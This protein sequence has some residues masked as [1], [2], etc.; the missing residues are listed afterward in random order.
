MDNTRDTQ[1]SPASH[2][3]Q[4]PALSRR[5]IAARRANAKN[6]TGPRT[7]DGKDAVRLNA[8]KH[9][10]FARD[11]V[12]LQLDGPART[13]EFNALL[14]ALL[15]EFQ[16]ESAS[17]RM[18]VDEVAASCWRTR[19]ILRYE[20]R[21]TW[22]D[23][24]DYRRD[25]N[26]ERPMDRVLAPMGYDHYG[27]RRRRASKLRRSGL[28]TLLLPSEV[29]MDKIVRFERTVKRNLYR[30]LKILRQIRAAR[31]FPATTDEP[32]SPQGSSA[33]GQPALPEK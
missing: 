24:D 32:S 1:P 14:D 17:E 20:C 30:A 7:P 25:A 8:L 3:N 10:I 27:D 21:E 19:R 6:S 22:V 11:V 9:G 13:E 12:N 33:T 18:L 15:E 28:D 4:P 26:T 31:R 23:E 2:E 29:D 16:P 5:Q